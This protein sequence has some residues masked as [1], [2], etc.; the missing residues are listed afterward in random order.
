M[1]SGG[2]GAAGVSGGG[3][4]PGDRRYC[5]GAGAPRR[6][7]DPR[8]V[9]VLERRSRWTGRRRERDGRCERLGRFWDRG[10]AGAAGAGN[11]YAGIRR[12]ASFICREERWPAWS[13]CPPLVPSRRTYRGA[14]W[15][16]HYYHR[17]AA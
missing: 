7:A 4:S 12:A 2:S 3:G 15:L 14:K 11:G 1:A 13:G 17:N 8:G 9:E 6:P 16:T 5:W 10:V